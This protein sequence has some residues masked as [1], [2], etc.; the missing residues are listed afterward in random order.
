[1]PRRSVHRAAAVFALLAALSGCD[2]LLDERA[3]ERERAL[4][5]RYPAVGQFV[6]I[7]G[8][9]VHARV[10]GQGPDLVLIHG[11][12][13]NLR[14]FTHDLAARLE[15]DYRVFAFDRPGLGWSGD[16]GA[17]GISPIV[18]ADVLRAAAR[19]LGARNPVV[20]GHSY[21][22]AVALA[23][24]LRAPDDPAA[25]VIL[26]GPSHTWPGERGAWTR[27]AASE[28]GG[29][30]AVPAVTAFAPL[31]LADR[32]AA[33][34]FTPQ[35]MPEGYVEDVAALLNLRRASLRTNARQL[36]ALKRHLEFMSPHYGSIRQP[37][38][39]LHGTADGIVSLEYHARR[40]AQDLPDAELTLL[41]G[42]GHMPHHAD[43]DAVVAA[44][45][46]AA[47]R[48]GLR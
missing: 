21:G 14:V 8:I 42:V 5:A 22:G 15:Q 36:N 10:A 34:V 17:A 23:W 13:G 40:L 26:A 24:A 20:L 2:R 1:M 12:S 16:L 46:R 37:V 7:D 38:E 27:L 45:H 44:I 47:Q 9:P 31:S 19:E 4:E 48:A 29:A 39:I 28:F 6:E 33:R 35:S 3:G 43:P 11:A 41:E 18:Q 25:L 30:T 32:L